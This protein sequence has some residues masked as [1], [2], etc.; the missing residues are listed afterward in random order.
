[1]V[2]SFAEQL[3]GCAAT[4]HGWVQSYG[5]RYVRPL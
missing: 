1:M 2:Q 3:D 5:S 4:E